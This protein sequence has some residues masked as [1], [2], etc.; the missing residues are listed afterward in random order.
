MAQDCLFCKIA[1]G[2]IPSTEVYSDEELYAFRDI[3]PAAPCHVL[4]IPRKH[5][6]KLTEATPQ[7]EALLGRMM[8]AANRIA[9]QEGL[10][11]SG[12]RCVVNCGADAGQEVMHI[13]LHVL[14]GRRMAWPPG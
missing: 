5:I 6:E 2:E 10:T 9:G 13:H 3:N 8:L 11:E 4:I 7:D 12:F 1:A 14:G